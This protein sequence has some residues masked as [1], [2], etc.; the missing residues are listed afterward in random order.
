VISTFRDS[1]YERYSMKNIKAADFVQLADNT[2]VDTIYAEKMP[3]KD[4]AFNE[5]VVR[6]F[7]DMLKRS[8]PGYWGLVDWL[9][10][11]SEF[12]PTFSISQKYPFQSI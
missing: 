5:K 1:F 6:A 3:E 8:I 4:F 2:A 7:P 12:K 11:D 9:G 10:T